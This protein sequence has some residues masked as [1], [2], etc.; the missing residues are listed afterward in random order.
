LTQPK[1][2][3]VIQKIIYPSK[4]SLSTFVDMEK[5]SSDI[6]KTFN[7]ALSLLTGYERR[8]YA[9]ALCRQYF[10]GSARQAERELNVSRKLV[11]KGLEEQE[12]GVRFIDNF[13]A[14]GRK[15]KKRP[16]EL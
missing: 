5:L 13:K 8:R 6:K 12:S 16:L 15:K 14:R 2:L 3:G 1:W 4:L 10:G 11:A 9:A 7:L